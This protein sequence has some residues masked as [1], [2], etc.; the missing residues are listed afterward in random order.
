MRR[1]ASRSRDGD[2]AAWSSSAPA[3]G[4]S[5]LVHGSPAQRQLPAGVAAARGW[6]EEAFLRAGEAA[7]AAGVTYIV[8]PLTPAQTN[9]F[10]TVAEAAEFV[11]RAALAGAAHHGGH[12]LRRPGR[13]RAAR[14]A[15]GPLAA[16]RAD[17]PRPPERRQPARPR[18]G[19]PAFRSRAAGAARGRATTAGSASSRS[20]TCPDGPAAAARAIGYVRGIE[21]SQG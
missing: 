12:L 18:P 17:R 4:G 19:R 14:G 6:V 11:G 8:E 9:C 15:A 16:D 10:N 20:S 2:A 21:E 5:Y 7:A 13:G 1:C 3:L